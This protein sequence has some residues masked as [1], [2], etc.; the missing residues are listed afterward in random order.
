M[1][2][3]I[4]K[5]NKTKATVKIDFEDKTSIK[6]TNDAFLSNYFYVGKSLTA[7]EVKELE[8]LSALT[9]YLNYALSL[10]KKSHYT[11]A[12]MREKLLK[13]G[14]KESYCNTIIKR[15]KDNDLIFD[16]MYM[17]DLLSY[18]EELNY[19]ENKIKKLLIAKKFDKE[20]VNSLK[21]P[22]K[23]ELFKA[24]NNLPLLEKKHQKISSN[25]K[26]NKIYTSLYALGFKKD[27]INEVMIFVGENNDKHN[28]QIDYEVSYR[29]LSKKYQGKTLYNKMFTALKNKGYEYDVIYDLLKEKNNGEIN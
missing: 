19:G 26:K 29:K 2:K 23:T 21:F 27:V 14:C 12:M 9:K 28:I 16:Q 24:K 6:I 4:S 20:K 3:V 5:I 15:L 10:L 25:K 17:L 22:Y 13:K 7:Q 11:E 8:K 18:Y 1:N